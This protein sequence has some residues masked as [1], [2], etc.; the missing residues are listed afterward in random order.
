MIGR[1]FALESGYANRCDHGPG[2]EALGA[3]MGCEKC[4]WKR[5]RKKRP[6]VIVTLTSAEEP[7]RVSYPVVNGFEQALIV[8]PNSPW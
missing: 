4:Y 7:E 8:M 5:V 3:G 2:E 1:F 6:A